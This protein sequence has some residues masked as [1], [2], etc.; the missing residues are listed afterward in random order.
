MLYIFDL[1]NVIVDIDFNRVL[2]AWSDLTRV[3]LATLTDG[4]SSA[5]GTHDGDGL[6][7]DIVSGIFY[8][9][10]IAH[11]VCIVSGQVP[12]IIDNGVHGTNQ[13]GSRGKLI[14]KLYD[15][16]FV[17][18]SKVE[19]A[20]AAG[21]QSCDSCFQIFLIYIKAK[22]RV[23]KIQKMESFIVHKGG[24]TVRHRTSKKCGKLCVTGNWNHKVPPEVS[25][26]VK[27]RD[28]HHN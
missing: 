20:D 16:I 21:L 15:L 28:N 6:T 12:V 3:P 26:I 11:T 24:N 17:W 14:Q 10:H 7:C 13:P 4:S 25:I 5:T 9:L 2:G 23:I 22:I 27:V 19:T 18:H 8:G 1:G